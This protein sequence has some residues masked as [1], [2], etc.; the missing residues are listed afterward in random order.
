[1]LSKRF[2]YFNYI[3]VYSSTVILN[4][5]I[6]ILLFPILD[7]DSRTMNFFFLCETYLLITFTTNLLNY[8]YNR[9]ATNA[10][11]DNPLLPCTVYLH[12]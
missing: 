5:R 1:M 7:T 9:S 3:I 2:I 8:N 10:I 6:S 12:T 4:F 11:D